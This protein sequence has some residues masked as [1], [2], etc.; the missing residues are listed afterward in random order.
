MSPMQKVLLAIEFFHVS[1]TIVEQLGGVSILSMMIGLKKIITEP[2]AVQ[3]IFPLPKHKGAV[4]KVR[5]TLNGLDLYDIEFIRFNKRG[6]K[7]ISKKAVESRM[8]RTPM[9]ELRIL[10]GAMHEIFFETSEI[11]EEIWVE[12]DKFL[13][14]NFP[15]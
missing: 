9:G 8:A 5:I 4:N 14:K 11:R 10:S 2:N 12:I 15:N 6:H 1:E 7:V 3:L 13:N